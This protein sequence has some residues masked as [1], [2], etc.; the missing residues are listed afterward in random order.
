[1]HGQVRVHSINCIHKSPAFENPLTIVMN[2]HV[3][4]IQNSESSYR[5]LDSFRLYQT[6]DFETILGLE[7][8]SFQLITPVF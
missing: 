7:S 2:L 1:M 3:L 6:R 8:R 5:E 4:D